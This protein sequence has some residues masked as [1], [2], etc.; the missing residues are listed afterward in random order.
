MFVQFFLVGCIPVIFL[1]SAVLPYELILFCLHYRLSASSSSS[2][3][4][5]RR[6]GTVSPGVAGHSARRSGTVSA[7]SSSHSARRS[8]TVSPGSCGYS[9]ASC[10][11]CST[12]AASRGICSHYYTSTSGVGG[13]VGDANVIGWQRFRGCCEWQCGGCWRGSWGCPTTT[14]T[15]RSVFLT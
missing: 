11:G 15:L 5:T 3:W 12:P 9:T 4:S 13:S 2:S 7:G 1:C 6:S 8:G 14:P 10:R